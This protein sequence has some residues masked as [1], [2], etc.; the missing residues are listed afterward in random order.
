MD[1]LVKRLKSGMAMSENEM[2]Q[3]P[4]MNLKKYT[5]LFQVQILNTTTSTFIKRYKNKFMLL[6]HNSFYIFVFYLLCYWLLT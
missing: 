5:V 3:Y 6:L 4:V 1:V 2:F